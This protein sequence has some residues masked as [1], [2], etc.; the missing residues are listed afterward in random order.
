MT[1]GSQIETV[2]SHDIIG[3][4][5]IK[6]VR[7]HG[8]ANVFENLASSMAEFV[9]TSEDVMSRDCCSYSLANLRN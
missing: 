3:R 2:V 7:E 9:A 6:G 1:G 8:L 5:M 4:M